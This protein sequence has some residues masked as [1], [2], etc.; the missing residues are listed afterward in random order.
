MEDIIES[1]SIYS[2]ILKL[3]VWCLLPMLLQA[4]VASAYVGDN[5]RDFLVDHGYL[6]DLETIRRQ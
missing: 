5:Y 2:W 6:T 3:S 1:R 4:S